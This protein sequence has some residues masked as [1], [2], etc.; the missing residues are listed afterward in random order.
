MGL[1][2]TMK[3]VAE[4]RRTRTFRRPSFFGSVTKTSP[5]TIRVDNR[6]DITGEAIVVMKEFQAGYYPTHR[7]HRL[8][9]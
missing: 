2:E 1:L 3:K 7:P 8:Q 6:F 4:R 9:G 5:L